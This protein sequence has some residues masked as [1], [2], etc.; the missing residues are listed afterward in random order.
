MTKLLETPDELKKVLLGHV[1]SGNY[2]VNVMR[3]GDLPSLNG[4][5][6]HNIAVTANGKI[7]IHNYK[8]Q[9]KNGL[10]IIYSS[11]TVTVTVTVDGANVIGPEQTADNGVIHTIDRVLLLEPQSIIDLLMQ[12][13]SN[14]STLI[15]TLNTTDLIGT[16]STGHIHFKK[17]YFV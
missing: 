17:Y 16:L 9:D 4:A 10:F 7:I 1:S 15:N 14:F 3:N 8:P 13:Y 5:S 11:V 12:N 6:H 2:P